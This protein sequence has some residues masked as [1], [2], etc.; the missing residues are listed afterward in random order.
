MGV[1]L[2]LADY[3]EECII[4]GQGEYLDLRMRKLTRDWRK[5]H[6]EQLHYSSNRY[7]FE[8]LWGMTRCSLVEY[9]A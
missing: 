8:E 7:S 4:K 9:R 6:D 2:G 3:G 5:E 1:K